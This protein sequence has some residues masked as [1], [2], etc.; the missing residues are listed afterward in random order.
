M[1]TVKALMLT[2]SLIRRFIAESPFFYAWI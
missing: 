1:K 2:G